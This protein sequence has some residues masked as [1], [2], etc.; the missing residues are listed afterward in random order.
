MFQRTLLLVGCPPGLSNIVDRE[1]DAM[2]K[3]YR[4]SVIT[5]SYN[6]AQFIEGTI[7][8]VLSQEYS[9]LEYIIID[10]G[11]KDG[12]QSIIEKYQ[13]QLY[14]WVS[15]PDRGQAAAINEGFK[16]ST[17]EIL[18]WLNSDD[19]YL[20][21]TLDKVNDFFQAHPEIDCV[22]GDLQF[23]DHTGRSLYVRRVVPYDL[24]T[25]IFSETPFGQP[26]SFWRRSVIE[27][28]GLLDESLKYWMDYEYFVRM[29]IGNIRFGMIREPLAA[30]RIHHDSKSST[31]LQVKHEEMN[32]VV[33]PRFIKLPFREQSLN[34]KFLWVMRWL[35]RLRILILRLIFRGQFDIPFKTSRLMKNVS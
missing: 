17:G 22:Y 19:Q 4:I 29:G 18:A 28:I 14:H 21:G 23:I 13:A 32:H 12:S 5:P 35:F 31:L 20:P 27:R 9:N 15:K 3:K 11:S 16:L 6:Q 24:G 7:Q 1:S 10:G 30:F 2:P 8:S 33:K 26:S 34:D 25:A